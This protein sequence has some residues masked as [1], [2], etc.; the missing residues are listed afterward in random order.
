MLRADVGDI[1][2]CMPEVDLDAARGQKK[3]DPANHGE[4]EPSIGFF[5]V[6]SP[7]STLHTLFGFF[8]LPSTRHYRFSLPAVHDRDCLDSLSCP[9]PPPI[10]FI[11]PWRTCASCRPSPRVSLVLTAL[12]S[13]LHGVRSGIP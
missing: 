2:I 6:V 10:R 3:A 1:M 12:V 4:V 7:S 13:A 8:P 5:S 9:P 11:A